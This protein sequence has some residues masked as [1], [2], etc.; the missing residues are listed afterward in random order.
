MAL[1]AANPVVLA[2]GN[3]GKLREFAE[4]FTPLG[5]HFK[6]QSDFGIAPP[7]ET[8]QSFLENALLKARHAA[9]LSGLPAMADDSGLEVDA[10]GGQPGIFSA[11]YAGEQAGDAANVTKLLAA[12][13]T[14]ADEARSARFRCVI[15]YVR[16]ADDAEPVVGVGVWE[17]RILAAP[18]GSGGFGYDPVF[19]DVQTGRSAAELDA[20]QKNMLSHRG[21]ALRDWLTEW[22]RRQPT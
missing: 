12:L 7:P 3:A 2:S 21:A 18:R 15:A 20:A 19:L 22:S 1:P 13:A 9:R 6:P 14:V 17:G 10:L 5:W 4:L 11:R 16:T 8:G